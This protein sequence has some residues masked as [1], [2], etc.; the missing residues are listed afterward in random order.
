MLRSPLALSLS[1]FIGL[2]AAPRPAEACQYDSC[3]SEGA[4]SKPAGLSLALP[5]EAGEKVQVLS[6]YGPNA[7][8]SLH[9]RAQDSSCA[10]DWHALDLVLPDR[11][12]WGKGQ[13]VLAATS[14]TVVAAG[15]GTSGWAAYGRRVYVEHTYDG[16]SYTTMYAHLDSVSVSAGQKVS[17]GD[18]LGTLGQSCNE[19]ESCGNFSTPHL[20]FALHR[21]ANFGGSGSGGSYGGRATLP[22]P[23]DGYTGLSQ[24]DQLLAQGDEEPPPIE[25]LPIPPE[26]ATLEDDGPCILI[27]GAPENY[28]T[29]DGHGGHALHTA[30]DN[31]SPDYI[32]GGIWTLELEEAGEYELSVYI[33]GG[34]PNPAAQATYKIAYGGAT[35]KVHLDHAANA[36]G[37]ASLGV[38]TLAAGGDQ[39]VR[40]GDNYDLP[41]DVGRQIAVDALRVAP[42]AACECGPEGAMES[43]PCG[44]NGEQV[45][46]CDGC[47]W[48]PWSTCDGEST[49]GD[50]T[51]SGGSDG[52][53]SDGSD[54][55]GSGSGGETSESGDPTSAGEDTAA[56]SVGPDSTGTASATGPSGL[57]PSDTDAGCSCTA[58]R[59]VPSPVSL[60]L[61]LLL[62]VVARRRDES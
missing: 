31:P 7:G 47:S 11:P 58:N 2:V 52:S 49:T 22:E 3:Q 30:L 37:W 41:S 27:G 13:P 33:P 55:S 46:V 9:C 21:D 12:N 38:F 20:H 28:A 60:G 5:F 34:L 56:T 51:D 25:C 59:D 48:G 1:F 6:G 29:I 53:G 42:S 26:G 10:N 39:W 50:A 54:G 61:G 44:F 4:V 57:T 45:R 19:A 15:W 17:Q 18:L 32:E 16:H 43:L 35:T 62:L 23:I 40:L 36:G 14:G 24:G 8:S